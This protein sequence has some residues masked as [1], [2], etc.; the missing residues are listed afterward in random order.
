MARP[1]QVLQV[2][3]RMGRGGIE[4][5]LMNVLRNIDRERFKF[6]FLVYTTQ[7]CAYDDEIRALGSRILPC[8]PPSRAIPHTQ[9]LRRVMTTEGPYDVVH[10]H[11]SSAVGHT[12]RMAAW[13]GIPVRIAHAHN[14]PKNVRRRLRSYVYR[15]ITGY[16]MKKYMTHGFGCSEVACA[17][18]FG[19]RWQSDSRCHVLY[20]GLDWEEFR[21]Q[22]DVSAIRE[23]FGL[24][25]DALVIGHI[26]RFVPQKNHDFWLEVST[27]VAGNRDDAYFLLVGDGP[28]R[29]TFQDKV[30]QWGLQDRF[31]FTGV[32][33]DVHCLL[34]AMNV[35]LFPSHFEGLGLA[36]VEAQAVGL[37]CV[38]SDTVPAEA[39]VIERQVRRLS[40]GARPD[41][42]AKTVLEAAAQGG[43]RN[44]LA[45]W[46]VVAHGQFS[47]AHC[48]NRLSEVYEG[49]A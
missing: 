26:G 6:D 47:L 1:I 29:K 3:S 48:L 44:H 21:K 25:Q 12:L 40:L 2:I 37:P 8:I 11:G 15:V 18:L 36:L 28:L 20:Y 4:T 16:W 27:Y 46:N 23:R 39:T 34:Q 24:P 17:H 31:V 38:V 49:K 33:P 43:R 13:A 22:A 41:V 35:F 30:R 14:A 42:W 7:A 10:T 9:D 45:S 32:R 5:W 19:E